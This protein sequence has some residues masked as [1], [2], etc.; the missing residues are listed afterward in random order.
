MLNSALECKN[1]TLYVGINGQTQ[2]TI[3]DQNPL[4]PHGCIVAHF[5]IITF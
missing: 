2:Y 5:F 4:G 3:S 1:H